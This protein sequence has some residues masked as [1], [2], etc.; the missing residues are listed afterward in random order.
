[1]R[2]ILKYTDVK[3]FIV[4]SMLLF[5]CVCM[6]AVRTDRT[7]SGYYRFLL[8]NL[9]LACVP[10]FLSTVLRIANHWRFPRTIQLA[11]FGLWLL[12]L[13]N[14]PYILTDILHLTRVSHAPAW[15]DLALLLSCAGTGL[16]L[17]YLSLI[18]VQGIVARNFGAAW[19]WTF[20]L[21]SLVLSGFAIYLGRFLRWNSWDVLLAP[22]RVFGIM[23]GLLH[24]WAHARPLAVTLI[25]GVILT[26]GYISLRVVLVHPERS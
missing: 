14:A 18:D 19:G 7:G 13:P 23:D 16:L 6:I 10:L 26:L 2:E 15:Y 22:S 25:F 8:G 17:G 21:V 20:A 12:F 1:M 11:V 5:W 4:L 24:P 3:R 9:F